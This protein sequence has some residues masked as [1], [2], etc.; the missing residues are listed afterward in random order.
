MDS[1]TN[2]LAFELLDHLSSNHLFLYSTSAI[3]PYAH[4]LD[5]VNWVAYSLDSSTDRASDFLIQESRVHVLILICGFFSLLRLRNMYYHTK[6][7]MLKH[8]SNSIHFHWFQNMLDKH[9]LRKEKKKKKNYPQ[10]LQV[11]HSLHSIFCLFSSLL[12]VFFL[13]PFFAPIGISNPLILPYF[14]AYYPL[15]P[16]LPSLPN[17]DS[18][19]HHFN[20]TPCVYIP[21]PS[22]LP[23]YLPGKI[24]TMNLS[25]LHVFTWAAECGWR[26]H[27][28]RL[29]GLTL[30]FWPRTSSQP[31]TLAGNPRPFQK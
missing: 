13:E 3:T 26:K 25:Q 8:E 12:L 6:I 14:P 18:M 17:W 15:M 19:T 28:I 30:D 23:S 7:P 5:V 31:S 27:I 9:V 4:I 2:N 11:S 22:F 1:P 20:P 21:C 24:P 16:L 10:N 29:S